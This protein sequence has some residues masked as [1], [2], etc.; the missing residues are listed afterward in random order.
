MF[1]ES[2]PLSLRT[3]LERYADEHRE[4]MR[5]ETQLVS[6]ME[7]QSDGSYTVTLKAQEKN[8][9]ELSITMRVVS[10]EMAK[11]IRSNW[12]DASEAIYQRMTELLLK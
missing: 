7:E 10:R 12:A 11:R 6:S 4:Q 9:V 2:L 8:T 3:R 1:G 5:Q